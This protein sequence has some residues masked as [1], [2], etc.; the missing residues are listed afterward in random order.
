MC[1]KRCV[2]S[3]RELKPAWTSLWALC[4]SENFVSVYLI[5]ICDPCLWLIKSVD[6]DHANTN[7]I[8]KQTWGTPQIS[9]E[10]FTKF[11]RDLSSLWFFFKMSSTLT[12][13]T[14]GSHCC[15]YQFQS[16]PLWWRMPWATAGLAAILKSKYRF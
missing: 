11:T 5:A 15:R 10:M 13:W 3:F 9:R 12:G 8:F 7:H 6:W 14:G 1:E 16:W 2:K 4:M